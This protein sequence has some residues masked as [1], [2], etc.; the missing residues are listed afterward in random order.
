MYKKLISLI[1]LLQCA[2]STLFAANYMTFTA[3]DYMCSFKIENHGGNDPDIQYSQDDGETWD[4]LSDGVIIY[5][6]KIGDKV[7]LK[8]NNPGG[9][10]QNLDVYTSFVLEKPIAASGSIMS[11]IDGEGESLVIPNSHCFCELFDDCSDLTKAPELPATTLTDHCY[12]GLFNFCRN[13]RQAPELPAEQL[14]PGC[15][16]SMFFGCYELESAPELPATHLAYDCYS[17]MFEACSTLTKAPKLPAMELAPS[18][19]E[20]MFASCANLKE[21]PELPATTLASDCYILMFAECD[22]LKQAP[23][24][25]ATELAFQCYWG[26]F[27]HC[28]GLTQAPRLPARKM[29]YGCYGN[30]F[31]SCT[32]LTQAPE[33]PATQMAQYCYE[34]MFMCCSSLTKAPDLPASNPYDACYTDMFRLCPNLSSILVN[35]SGWDNTATISWVLDVAPTGTFYCPSALPEEYGISRIPEGWDVVH[36]DV[37]VDGIDADAPWSIHTSDL[38]IFV[39]GAQTDVEVYNLTG[40]LIVKEKANKEETKLTMSHKGV[41]IVKIG[42]KSQK[43]E[44]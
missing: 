24:L 17:Y 14:A 35:F 31:Y 9:F 39:T 26:M 18:C 4:K 29:E 42:N 40:S 16:G 25:P 19:Y 27:S 2:T 44:L 34:Q 7:L 15:Y 43:V 3:E 12:Y 23:A 32:S 36:I 11:L 33:L 1:I 5:L 38:T 10:N 28:T 8:G 30:M 41:Y 37:G 22:S 21:A 6:P 13:L 20:S